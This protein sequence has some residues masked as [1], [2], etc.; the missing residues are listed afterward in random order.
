MAMPQVSLDAAVSRRDRG[1]I[2]EISIV[3]AQT[4]QGLLSDCQGRP[5]WH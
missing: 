3:W 5:L 1:N 2:G 4:V